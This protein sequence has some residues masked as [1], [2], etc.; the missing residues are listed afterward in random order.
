MKVI[1][2]QY[3]ITLETLERYPEDYLDYIKNQVFIVWAKEI[4]KNNVLEIEG[5]DEYYVKLLKLEGIVMD[6]F[7]HEKIKKLINDALIANGICDGRKTRELLI[8][9]KEKI[10]R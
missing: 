5:S 7:E 9:I 3:S 10:K 6:R 1:K 4:Q 2:S 8:E